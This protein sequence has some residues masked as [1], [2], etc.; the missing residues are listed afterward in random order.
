MKKI[1]FLFCSLGVSLGLFA[2]DDLMNMLDAEISDKPTM[3]FATFKST[4]V[5]NLHSNETMKKKHLDFRI[6]H[7][8]A[9]MDITADNYYGLYTMFG[10]DGAQM[11]LGMEYGVTDKLMIGAGRSTVDKTYDGFI[12]YKIVEQSRGK[13]SFPLSIVYFGNIGIN[14]LKWVDDT[15]Q[16]FLSS[17]FSFTNQLIFTR[18]FNDIISVCISPTLVHYNTVETKSQPNDIFAI[19]LGTSIKINKSVRLNLEYIPRIT[20]RDEPKQANGSASYY[21][22]FGIG[23]DFETGGHVFQ[24]H[25]T[26][27]TGMIEQHFIARNVNP[28]EFTQIRFGFNLSRTF[29]FDHTK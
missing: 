4:R 27:A 12:K 2:Q 10:L 22:A 28:I 9:P 20:G 8:F 26:N 13:K 3:V 7:R 15:K 24:I 23:F 16:N 21:D 18:K 17:R 1:A 19:G 25:I 29:S 14:T 11:R 5:I 6:Q